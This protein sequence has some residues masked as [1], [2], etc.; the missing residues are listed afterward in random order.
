MHFK[1]QVQQLIERLTKCVLVMQ[2]QLL[3]EC[4][5]FTQCIWM[6]VWIYLYWLVHINTKFIFKLNALFYVFST[7][8]VCIFSVLWVWVKLFLRVNSYVGLLH[9]VNTNLPYIMCVNSI[10]TQYETIQ[11]LKDGAF[12]STANVLVWRFSKGNLGKQAMY[13]KTSYKWIF[14][15][16]DIIHRGCH[17]SFFWW[18][19]PFSCI[20]K[21]DSTA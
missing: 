18:K 16:C 10:C 15:I 7:C 6:Y 20:N 13:A 2:S 8:M 5:V 11:S 14:N 4:I 1:E 19:N 3:Y 21:Y 17:M 12:S 9:I